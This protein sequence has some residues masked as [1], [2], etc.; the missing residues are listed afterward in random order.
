MGTATALQENHGSFLDMPQLAPG[1]TRFWFIRHALVE[2]NA[3]AALYGA[4]D[5]PLCPESM[6]VQRPMYEA[7][8]RRLPHPAKWFITPLSRTRRTAEAICSAGYAGGAPELTVVPSFIEQDLGEWQGILHAD[9]PERLSLPPHVFWP[10]SGAERPPGGE[11]MV[12]VCA[13]VGAALD[14][15][16]EQNEGENMVVVSHGGSIRAVLAHALR[17]HA[18]T[19]LHFSIQNLSLTIVERHKGIWRVVTANELPGI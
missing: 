6:V 2:Q 4:L 19:A 17:V 3:R 13:R 8:A 1:V 5:V 15:M 14:E 11:S 10:M 18:D 16:A 9:L 7:L 12:D